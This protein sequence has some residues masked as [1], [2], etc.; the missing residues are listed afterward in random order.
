MAHNIWPYRSNH[1]HRRSQVHPIMPPS[2][3]KGKAINKDP[4]DNVD[5]S[6]TKLN[7]ICIPQAG[8]GAWAFHGWQKH[9][10]QGVEI[11]PVE[12][13][14]RNSRMLE[15]K[16]T[17]MA[18]LI[19]GLVEG[20]LTLG[21]FSTPYVL[22]GHS[23]GAWIAYELLAELI[24]QGKD[25]LCQMLIVSGVR[26]PHLAALEHD[27]DTFC[28]ALAKLDDHEFWAHFE[29]R[30]GKNPELDG[31][32][33]AMLVMPLLR[34]DFGILESY[35]PTRENAPLPVPLRACQA[36]GDNRLKP[37]QVGRRVWPA[38]AARAHACTHARRS[39]VNARSYHGRVGQPA[40]R[41]LH[42]S[43]LTVGSR[44]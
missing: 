32:M 19:T 23:L 29:R 21:A 26:P 34:A 14:G 31:D 33:I 25:G 17:S 24:R 7:V 6:L 8:M 12:L 13:P 28:P 2:P 42:T 10:P 15:P 16:P 18:E 1:L 40:A 9:A 35:T 4:R 36:V 41:R 37:G 3:A 20:L 30:Y 44:P 11:L 5:S 38:R 39:A 43:C 27:A 22:L